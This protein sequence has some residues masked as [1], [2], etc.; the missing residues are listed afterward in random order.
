[1]TYFGTSNILHWDQQQID[2][3]ILRVKSRKNVPISFIDDSEP[4]KKNKFAPFLLK[5][6]KLSK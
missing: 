5:L 2:A 1:M 6:R 4:E 3:A